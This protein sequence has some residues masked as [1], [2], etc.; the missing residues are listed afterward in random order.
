MVGYRICCLIYLTF[1]VLLQDLIHDLKSELGGNFED[2]ILGL[3]MTPE[4]FDAYE[5]KRAMRVSSFR[6]YSS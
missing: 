2:V 3:M 1:T 6:R 5:L 4:E